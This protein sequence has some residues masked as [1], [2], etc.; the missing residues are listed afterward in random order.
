MNLTPLPDKNF[1]LSFRC[2]CLILAV[3]SVF[4][5]Q[6]QTESGTYAVD[7]LI[8]FGIWHYKLIIASRIRFA[9]PPIIIC[10]KHLS[11]FPL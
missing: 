5:D 4:A 2:F 1:R 11:A 8:N 3:F 10:R 9:I 6:A 7:L